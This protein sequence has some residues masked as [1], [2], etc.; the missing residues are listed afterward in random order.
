MT[1]WEIINTIIQRKNYKSY[2]EIGVRDGLCFFHVNCPDKTGVDPNPTSDHTTHIMKSDDYFKSLNEYKKFDIIFID[3]LHLEYQVDR[4]ISNSL[5]HLS[6]GGTIVIH[7]CNPPT[8]MHAGEAPVFEH[9][10]N[11]EWNGTV[12]L[13]LM[14]LRTSGELMLITVDADWGVGI[15]TKE[16]SEPIKKFKSDIDLWCFFDKNRS[17]ILNLISVEEFKNKDVFYDMQSKFKT[18]F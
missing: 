3:G 18:V 2:L 8:K 15:L 4:D 17:K 16:K 1:R 5:D 13:S 10:I 7:D 6:E 12:Y 11:G 14:K 9:P